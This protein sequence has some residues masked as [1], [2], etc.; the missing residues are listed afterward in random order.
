MYVVYINYLLFNSPL[1][2]SSSMFAYVVV[3]VARGFF[4]RDLSAIEIRGR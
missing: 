1:L 3:C 4:L 2:C